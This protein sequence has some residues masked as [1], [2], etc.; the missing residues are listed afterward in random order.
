MKASDQASDPVMISITSYL[1]SLP[2]S[3]VPRQTLARLNMQLVWMY[4]HHRALELVDILLELLK[5]SG[6]TKA[7]L[8]RKIGVTP[9]T[10]TKLINGNQ[11]G[12]LQETKRRLGIVLE[13]FPEINE[14]FIRLKIRG[15]GRPPTVTR[16]Y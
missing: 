12:M 8:A 2:V 6:W 16:L 11:K 1:E 4:T 10:V 13:D 7:D 15:V 14:K 9:Q 5:E 3:K